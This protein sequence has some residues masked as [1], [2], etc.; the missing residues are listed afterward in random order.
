MRTIYRTVYSID[1][2]EDPETENAPV[3]RERATAATEVTSDRDPEVMAQT[4]VKARADGICK[5]TID[6]MAKSHGEEPA[7]WPSD[8]LKQTYR[9]VVNKRRMNEAEGVGA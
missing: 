9:A 3:R 2:G 6:S 7:K 5:I 4:I 1:A 8:V